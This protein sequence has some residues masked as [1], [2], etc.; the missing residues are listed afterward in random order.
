MLYYAVNKAIMNNR[1]LYR[2]FKRGM[3]IIYFPLTSL[4]ALSVTTMKN[5][6]KK[7]EGDLELIT[8]SVG[9]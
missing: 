4:K 9:F 3:E 6:K 8:Q 5:N 7:E 2:V 1:V